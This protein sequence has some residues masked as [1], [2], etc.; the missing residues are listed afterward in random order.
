M[1]G[2][3]RRAMSKSPAPTRDRIVPNAVGFEMTFTSTDRAAAATIAPVEAR[4][5]SKSAC[6]ARISNGCVPSRG[7]IRQPDPSVWQLPEPDFVQP[8]LSRVKPALAGS[9]GYRGSDV[10][11][12]P[13]FV[14][15]TMLSAMDPRVCRRTLTTVWRSMRRVNACRNGRPSSSTR[16]SAGGYCVYPNGW[17]AMLKKNDVGNSAG[18]FTRPMFGSF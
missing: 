16:E 4:M 2:A 11:Y 1:S 3:A 14:G 15:A 9:Y 18:A 12:H 17:R 10:L 5:G 13:S 7:K 6:G 8:A